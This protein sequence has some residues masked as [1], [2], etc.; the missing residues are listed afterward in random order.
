M[1]WRKTVHFTA[2]CTMRRENGIRTLTAICWTR[3]P[4]DVREVLLTVVVVF[5]CALHHSTAV[6][7]LRKPACNCRQWA[8]KLDRSRGGMVCCAV[9]ILLDQTHM[10]IST[11]KRQVS[12]YGS[13]GVYL[14]RSSQ[15]WLMMHHFTCSLPELLT[16]YTFVQTKLDSQSR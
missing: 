2:D 12:S 9:C 8:S 5:L 1:L 11:A 6:T 15:P 13:Q 4:A 7:L 14:R 10:F 3:H 16:L